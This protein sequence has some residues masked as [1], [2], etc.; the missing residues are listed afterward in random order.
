MHSALSQEI[1]N[2]TEAATRYAA[3]HTRIPED[4]LSGRHPEHFTA[5][6][7]TMLLRRW[8]N[9]GTGTS[10]PLGPSPPCRSCLG[11]GNPFDRHTFLF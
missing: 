9:E 3:D 8:M 11:R 6:F 1:A 5:N 4:R 2:L 7:D 10:W